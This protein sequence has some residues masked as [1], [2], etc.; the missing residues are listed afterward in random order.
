MTSQQ[1]FILDVYDSLGKFD[2]MGV[3]SRTGISIIFYIKKCDK[4]DITK[5]IDPFQLRL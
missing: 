2:T 5:T 3:T 4:K 1:N